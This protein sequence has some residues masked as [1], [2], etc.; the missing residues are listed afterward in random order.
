MS[1]PNPEPGYAELHLHT[2]YSLLD[3]AALP[4]EIVTRAAELGYHHLAVTDHD[5]LY[6]ALEFANAADSAGIAPITGAEMTLLDG[7]HITLLVESAAGYANLCRLITA[8]HQPEPGTGWPTEPAARAARGHPCG[9]RSPRA[10][11]A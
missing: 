4:E 9:Q 10:G 8:A 3:G 5:G 1:T 2:A 11:P 7:S 6:G